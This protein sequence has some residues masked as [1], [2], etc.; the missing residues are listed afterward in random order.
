MILKTYLKKEGIVLSEKQQSHLGLNVYKCFR[1]KY[2]DVIINRVNILSNGKK[3]T[4]NDYPREFFHEIVFKQLILRFIRK[5]N[6][7]VNKSKQYE[8]R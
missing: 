7:Q 4:V 6:I 8:V 5:N 3:M 2:P 1:S